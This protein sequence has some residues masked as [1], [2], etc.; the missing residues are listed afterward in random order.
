M[1]RKKKRDQNIITIGMRWI[2]W[3][4]TQT[5]SIQQED[6]NIIY[7]TSIL[8]CC[9][10][11][12]LNNAALLNSSQPSRGEAHSSQITRRKYYKKEKRGICATFL[13]T[14][15]SYSAFL[16]LPVSHLEGRHTVECLQI[17]SRVPCAQVT[18]EL[19]RHLLIISNLKAHSRIIE[20]VFQLCLS[21][22]L[23]TSHFLSFCIKLL[24]VAAF[25]KVKSGHL[26]EK[27]FVMSAIEQHCNSIAA[28]KEELSQNVA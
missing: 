6:V 14:Q 7:N 2:G 27:V 19:N 22:N 4:Q 1:K 24:F 28:L 23:H 11:E 13:V 26:N 15:H 16:S 8:L 12:G 21:C 20:W 17:C 25:W 5:I 10:K 3:F 9:N 18:G